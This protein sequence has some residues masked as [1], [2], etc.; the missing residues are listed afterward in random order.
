MS[1]QTTPL[2]PVFALT[3]A[4]R[5]EVSYFIRLGLYCQRTL[6]KP[7]I[8]AGADALSVFESSSPPSVPFRTLGLPLNPTKLRLARH[9][10]PN[11]SVLQ[12]IAAFLAFTAQK[13]RDAP[14]RSVSTLQGV[15][16]P[17]GN[18]PI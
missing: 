8:I 1:V 15:P 18:S 5:I 12:V 13:K 9:P 17:F 16:A 7:A 10:R 4:T 11:P 14:S 6:A 2:H 3:V